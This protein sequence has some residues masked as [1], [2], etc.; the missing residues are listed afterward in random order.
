MVELSKLA[1]LMKKDWDRRVSHD[2]RFWMSDGHKD[3]RAMWESG[4]R[5]FDILSEGI[6]DLESRTVLE[7]G[8]GVGRLL[9]AALPRCRRIIGIDVSEKAIAKARDLLG[10]DPKLELHIGNGIDLS[11]IASGSIDYVFS[12]AAL[13]S[14]PTRVIAAYL[15]E[16]RRVLAPNGIVRLQVYIGEEMLVAEPDTL[17]LRC[18]Q[19][20]NFVKACE[21]SGLGVQSITEL[22][23]PFKVSFK[24]IGIEAFIA[25][26]VP[27]SQPGSSVDEVATCLLPS[28]EPAEGTSV[29]PSE[30]EAWMT[31][32]YAESL[33]D[34]GDVEKARKMLDYVEAHCKS[35]AIDTSDL[36]QR[37]TDKSAK[38]APITSKFADMDLFHRNLTALR[39]KFPD[40]ARAVEAVG[41]VESAEVETKVTPQ[42]PAV[43]YRSQCLDHIEKPVS[44]ATTWIDR[45]LSEPRFKNAHQIVLYGFGGGYHVEALL[46][47]LDVRVACVEPSAAVLRSA[48]GARDFTGVFSRLTALSVGVVRTLDFVGVESELLV[49]PQTMTMSAAYAADVKS[50]FYGKR[51]MVSLHPKIGVVGPL[52]GG[53]LPITQYVYNSL[54]RMDQRVRG[55][56]VSG[57]NAGYNLLD[58]FVNFT[59]RRKSVANA[60]I[61]MIS[62]VLLESFTEKPV[63][64]LICMAQAP[65]SPQVLVELRKRGVITVLWFVE[66][67]LRFTYWKDMAKFYDFVFTIQKGP[68][69]EAIKQA[70]AGEVHY[71]P[72]ACDQ[73]IHVPLALSPEERAQW[74]SPVSFVGAGYYNRTQVFASLAALPFKI[75]G[76]EWPGNKPFDRLVQEGGR[77]LAPEEYIKIFNSTDINLNLHSSTE[78]DG[79]DPYGDF[80]NPRVFELASA[81]A[82]QLVDEREYL[83]DCF[84]IGK[85]MITFSSTPDLKEKIS[86]YLAHPGERVAVT[87]KAR[88][89][90]LRDHTYDKRIEQMLST[91]YATRYEQLRAR[92]ESGPWGRMLKRAQAYPELYER[93]EKSFKRGEEPNL[94][95][96]ISDIVT[97]N[98][99]LS[100][101][102]QKLLFMYHVRK[103]IINMTREETGE[104][105]R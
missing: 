63:D 48:M 54:T 85:E 53:T 17:H 14:M 60:Y 55:L 41:A 23:L 61:E 79:V 92:E 64:I 77:R 72:T 30:V 91:I 28:G 83:K 98:G 42:G 93:C 12:F 49:R 96:L 25:S 84:E 40:A 20:E 18:Y 27:N 8:C 37:I 95:A 22:R 46:E 6:L 71:L 24:E 70:G 94:D 50:L 38:A 105:S 101:T 43:Y 45:N 73:G 66:D 16:I 90:A 88:E 29:S 3:D 81:G 69:L 100:E 51:G 65:I 82:F 76:T 7:V 59:P 86:Y 32:G 75:W 1:A 89:R 34:E 35:A 80:L 39:E 9:K 31:V 56:D 102:E 57:F 47:K 26:L 87:Q 78:R 10:S 97:G 21:M 67:Y 52:Q 74:G 36:L 33:A 19:R 2:Y 5:D 13:T 103:Q 99:H 15:K 4:R 104:K 68:C 11:V 58:G 62:Y 44:A